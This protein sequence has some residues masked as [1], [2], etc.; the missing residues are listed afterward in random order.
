MSGSPHTHVPPANSQAL[1]PLTI[2]PGGGSTRALPQRTLIVAV[3]AARLNVS[4]DICTLPS[5]NIWPGAH[6][7]PPRSSTIRVRDCPVGAHPLWICTESGV[8]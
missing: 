2:G 1:G 4:I 8:A 3:F 6:N 5:L 7:G